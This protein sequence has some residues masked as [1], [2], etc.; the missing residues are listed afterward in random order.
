[1]KPAPPV[2]STLIDFLT[3]YSYLK[4]LRTIVS[5]SISGSGSISKTRLRFTGSAGAL[6]RTERAPRRLRFIK[7][8][9]AFE[10]DRLRLGRARAPAL[11]VASS[12]TQ[13]IEPVPDLSVSWWSRVYHVVFAIEILVP[14]AR[15]Q[16]AT[17]RLGGGRS[18]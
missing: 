8:C 15:F 1:M 7:F 16:R 14:P 6:A 12:P 18:M 13:Q 3:C 9:L 4:P 5:V 10:K 2:T 17:F 11:P